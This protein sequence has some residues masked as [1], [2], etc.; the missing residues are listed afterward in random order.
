MSLAA[1]SYSGSV[2]GVGA[3]GVD[4]VYITDLVAGTV[5]SF[6]YKITE[7]AGMRCLEASV[8]CDATLTS[9]RFNVPRSTIFH[10]NNLAVVASCT[11][12]GATIVG[13]TNSKQIVVGVTAGHETTVNVSIM[14]AYV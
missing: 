7:L 1:E 6:T 10:T 3:E 4:L 5:A 9:L 12:P 2:V 13:I 11:A 14:Y 8:V